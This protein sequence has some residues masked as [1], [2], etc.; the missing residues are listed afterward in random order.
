MP[1]VTNFCDAGQPGVLH[2]LDAHDRV[3]V[4]EAAGVLAVGADAADDG[5]QVDDDVGPAVGERRARSSARRAGR[6]RGCGGRRRPRRPALEPRDDG[7]PRKPAPPVTMT[8][9]PWRLPIRLVLTDGRRS[10]NRI[11]VQPELLE[12][13]VEHHLCTSSANVVCGS[14]PRTRSAFEASPHEVIDLGRAEVARVDVDV[15]LPVAARRGR[16]PVSTNSRTL[17]ISP[18]ATT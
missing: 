12:V 9:R 5:R 1:I 2:Q 18:V 4:E 15:L 16:R 11:E 10:R 7:R 8:R 6:S 3:L 13:G 14:Q 17:C